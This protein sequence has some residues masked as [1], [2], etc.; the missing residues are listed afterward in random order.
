[1]HAG[2]HH[3]GNKETNMLARISILALTAAFL[4]MTGCVYHEYHD[5][6]WDRYED[7]QGADRDQSERHHKSDR[8]RHED[9]DQQ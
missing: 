1:M 6:D 7:Q 9:Q 2:I 4:L 3:S 5:R 8:R